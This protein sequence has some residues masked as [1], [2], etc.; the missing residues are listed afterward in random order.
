MWNSFPRIIHSPSRFV[1]SKRLRWC[2]FNCIKANF[3]ASWTFRALWTMQKLSHRKL[4]N[5]CT[6]QIFSFLGAKLRSLRGALRLGCSLLGARGKIHLCVFTLYGSCGCVAFQVR[7][8]CACTLSI[9]HVS[10]HVIE[11]ITYLNLSDKGAYACIYI[12]IYMHPHLKPLH[13][14]R[15]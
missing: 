13:P 10:C 11:R 3:V 9:K 1:L 7:C 5:Y 14:L 15:S 6:T 2:S 4:G 8:G 12:Y